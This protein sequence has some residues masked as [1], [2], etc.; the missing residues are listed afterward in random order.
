MGGGVGRPMSLSFSFLIYKMQSVIQVH[1]YPQFWNRKSLRR[2]FFWS[3]IQ[4]PLAV[5]S[6]LSG[7]DVLC[8]YSSHQGEGQCLHVP[9]QKSCRLLIDD[10][11]LCCRLCDRCTRLLS[12]NPSKILSSQNPCPQGVTQGMIS[13]MFMKNCPWG[14]W[15]TRRAMCT[16][17]LTP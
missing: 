6:E 1:P 8:S 16:Q 13:T 10:A 11:W 5:K 4:T 12:E 14:L 2:D 15:A 3:L 7:C 9:L 17:S